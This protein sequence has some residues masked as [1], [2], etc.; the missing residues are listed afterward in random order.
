MNIYRI[1]FMDYSDSG[2]A[3]EGYP[4]RDFEDV[5]ANSMEEAIEVVR[6]RHTESFHFKYGQCIQW[7]KNE[8]S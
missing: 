7:R 8:Q 5:E 6:A 2:H 3:Y 1:S 4:K